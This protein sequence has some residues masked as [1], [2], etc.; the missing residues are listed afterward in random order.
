MQEHRRPAG[1][2]SEARAWAVGWLPL[3]AAFT[4]YRSPE[5]NGT[6]RAPEN[7]NQAY[8]RVA[9]QIQLEGSMRSS[10]DES[11]GHT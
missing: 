10:A 4:T 3:A 7:R 9:V 6:C 2:P 8:A 11:I 1:H 5:T